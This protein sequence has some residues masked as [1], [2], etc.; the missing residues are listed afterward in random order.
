MWFTAAS[1]DEQTERPC[2]ARQCKHVGFPGTGCLSG[3]GSYRHRPDAAWILVRWPHGGGQR[4]HKTGSDCLVVSCGVLPWRGAGFGCLAAREGLDDDHSATAFWARLV[5]GLIIAFG[6]GCFIRR[7]TGLWLCNQQ[8]P[9][10]RDPVATDGAKVSRTQPS[11]SPADQV[12][13]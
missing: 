6:A 7:L 9:D 11:G 2:D 3:F 12:G 13:W 8:T 10:L 5:R 1:L 4:L